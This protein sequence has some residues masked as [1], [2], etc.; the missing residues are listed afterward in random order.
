VS[1]QGQHAH[2]TYG[3][4]MQRNLGQVLPPAIEARW[5]SCFSIAF[6]A[7]RPV[8]FHSRVVTGGTLW[9][10]AE[11]LMAPLGDEIAGVECLFTALA[12]WRAETAVA[13]GP[14]IAS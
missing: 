4:I 11:V 8:R 10:E 2:D 9:L 3:P 1:L 6:S 13:S 7:A 12:S 14:E 5:R